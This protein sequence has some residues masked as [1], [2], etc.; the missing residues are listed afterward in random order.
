MKNNLLHITLLLKTPLIL[1]VFLFF[2]SCEND[3]QEIRELTAK[4]DSAIFSA[5][6]VEVTYSSKGRPNGLMKA[7]L[8]VRYMQEKDKSY[9]EF[10]EGI[11]MF[12]YNEKGVTTS[13]L[14]S[15]YAIYY[16][17]EERWVAKYDVE[18]VNENGEMLN[19]EYLVWSRKEEK[20]TSDQFVKLT[21][22]DGVIYGD[23]GFESNQT[24][25]SWEVING[26]GVI[27]VETDEDPQKKKVKGR[28][29]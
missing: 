14:R 4:Q 17:D 2:G 3:M 26:R 11:K 6:N 10:P 29:K 9:T 15:N 19:T 21:T 23:D 24:F 18:V 28:A 8:L 7:P 16:E 13:T 12:F 25:T 20:I 27:D 22:N 1:G 5:Q